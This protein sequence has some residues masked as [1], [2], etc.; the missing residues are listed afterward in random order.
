MTQFHGYL[1]DLD[2]TLIDSAEGLHQALNALQHDHHMPLSPK[3]QMQQQISHGA[4]SILQD[5]CPLDTHDI[6]SLESEF[7]THYTK[8][9]A[10]GSPFF[11]SIESLIQLLNTHDTP[12]GIVTN[13]R[14][15]QVQQVLETHPLLNTAKTIIC[16]DTLDKAKPHP[17]PLLKAAIDI[18]TKPESILFVGDSIHDMIASQKAGMTGCLA[19]YGYIDDV[20]AKMNWPHDYCVDHSN[21]LKTLIESFLNQN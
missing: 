15:R 21:E 7:L 1:F 14:T 5:T 3:S 13:K 12:W 16:G 20:D 6:D 19:F 11:P 4:K 10:S 2:G 8:T 9:I 18:H 17:E